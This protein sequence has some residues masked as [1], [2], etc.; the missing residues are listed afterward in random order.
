[1]TV[2][3]R[4]R[5]WLR[6]A[7]A[8][9]HSIDHKIGCLDQKMAAIIQGMDNQSQLLNSKLEALVEGTDNQ[10]K[11]LNNK[12]EALIAGM[13]NQSRLL[14][15]SWVFDKKL[16]DFDDELDTKAILESLRVDKWLPVRPIGAIANYPAKSTAISHDSLL[17]WSRS[18]EFQLELAYFQD[19]PTNSLMG[20]K[21]KAL[22]YHLLR[23]IR[24][25]VVIEVGTY[26]AGTA[27]IIGRA[28]W[29][30]GT[31]MLHTADPYGDYCY[32]LIERLPPELRCH[33]TFYK[34]NSMG[35][36]MSSPER[37]SV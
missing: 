17:A 5:S 20:G 33:I 7:L 14:D 4:I 25:Q 27:E 26:F 35:S 36:L 30:N 16:K 1:M 8:I 37:R 10:S 24:P 21:A 22:I 13:K 11:L 18:E 28:L 9:E 23:I 2:L 12:F 19:Y 34:M 6:D 15:R 3:R 29:E 32:P 31:G